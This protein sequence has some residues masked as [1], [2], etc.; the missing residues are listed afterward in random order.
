MARNNKP[1]LKPKKYDDKKKS[2]KIPQIDL[3][4]PEINIE[5][6]SNLNLENIRNFDVNSLMNI[7]K[8]TLLIISFIILLLIMIFS[9]NV[10]NEKVETNNTTIEQVLPTTQMLGNNSLGYVTKEGPY[11]NTNSSVKI[12]YILGVHPREKGAHR[13]MEQAFKESANDLNYCYYL[14]KVNV[15][16]NPS[17]YSASRM[18]GQKLANEFIVDDAVNNNFTFAVDS[19]YSNGAWG[20]QRFVFTPNRNNSLS[21]QLGQAIADNFDWITYFTPDNPTSPRYLTGPL[22]D[23]GVGAIIYEA[24][25]DDERNVTLEHD[26]E[27]VNFI[28]NW[29]FTGS[30]NNTTT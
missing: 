23:G 27:L 3:K 12:A 4:L 14:Y 18:N 6:I 1:S 20:V 16:K 2:F 11:G 30:V 8:N 24:Y 19:H 26:R 17:D 21:Y 29:N 5:E 13:L 10:N 9:V 25:V 15:T 28:D 22:N 7:N